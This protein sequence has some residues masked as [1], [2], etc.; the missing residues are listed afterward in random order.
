MFMK[1]IIFFSH[2]IFSTICWTHLDT[3]GTDYGS[4]ESINQFQSSHKKVNKYYLANKRIIESLYFM[5]WK[6]AINHLCQPLPFFS[7]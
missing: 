1:I 4:H 6:K 5:N 2:D 3:V 7:D